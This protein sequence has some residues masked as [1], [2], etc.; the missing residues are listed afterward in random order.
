LYPACVSAHEFWLAPSTYAAAAGDTVS[1]RAFVGSG[2]RGEAKPFGARRVQ[3]FELRAAATRDL[4]RLG[5]NGGLVYA[6]FIAPDGGGALVAYQSDFAS[7]ELPGPR[8]EQ[9]LAAEGLDGPRTARARAKAEDAPGR[10]RYARCAKT[11][12]AGKEPRRAEQV[13]GMP[14]EIV[15]LADPAAADRLPLQVLYGGEP[16]AATLVRAWNTTATLAASERD[17]VPPACSSRTDA[18]GIVTLAIDHPGEWLVNA[19]HMVAS[20]DPDA[21]WESY[22]ASL[23]FERP[24]KRKPRRR[25]ASSR[26]GRNGSLRC[27]RTASQRRRR[28]H[29]RPARWVGWI[30]GLGLGGLLLASAPRPARAHAEP[31]SYVDLRLD[32]AGIE[33]EVTAHVVDL[34]GAIGLATPDSLRSAG[35]VERHAGELHAAITERLHLDADGAAVHPTWTSLQIVPERR[36]VSF[37]FRVP[38]P[39]TPRSVHLVGPLFASDPAHETYFN[40]YV[41]GAV[42]HQD[43]LEAS[44]TESTYAHDAGPNRRAIVRT[45][46]AAGVHHIFIGPDHILFVIGLLLLGGGVRRLLKIV[47]AFTIAHS[48]T[49]ALAATG[50]VTPSARVVEPA[51][52]LS[53]VYVGADNLLR[54]RRRRDTRALAAAGFGLVHGFGFA[55]VLGEMGLPSG[56]L[57]ASLFAFNAGVE[58]GQACIVLA[59]AP[60]LAVLRA[61]RP[62]AARRAVIAGSAFVLI[63]GAYWFVQRAFGV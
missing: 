39:L 56:A 36:A 23:T 35:F 48:I 7:I 27:S 49:L 52:A 51:I 1:I 15:A 63:A 26:R 8:F 28:P 30:S 41:S 55:S 12:I 57:A 31:Y 24:A 40:V 32:S 16:L 20:G 61:H 58:I 54:G 42:R 60:L 33:G 62:A 37:R 22:W 46:L 21:D 3:R 50:A 17:S 4:S 59:V 44:H 38:E 47:T 25:N 53:I 34:A 29:P 10:E 13:I 11:W 14:L 5:S 45:F 19:V 9:Y 6:R 18:H 43:L 2:F